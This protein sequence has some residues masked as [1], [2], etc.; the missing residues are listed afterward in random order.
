MTSIYFGSARVKAYSATTKSGKSVIRV[1][2]ETSDHY[3]LASLLRQLDEID[4]EQKAA[5]KK[6]P[7]PAKKT[8]PLAL[9]APPL[10]L[11]YFPEDR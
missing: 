11:P 10:A 3:E 7:E 6:K 8:E 5:K 1:E 9:P 2:L 4:A